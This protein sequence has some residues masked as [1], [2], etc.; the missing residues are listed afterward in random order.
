MKVFGGTGAEKGKMR[1]PHGQWLDARDPKKPVL[2]VCDRANARL[3]RFTLDGQVIDA[4]ESGKVVLFPAHAKTRG[5]VLLVPDLHARVSLFDKGNKV[6]CHLG[7]DGSQAD[8]DWR[9]KVLDGFKVRGQPK[10][11]VAGKF[12]HPHDACFDKDGNIFVVEWVATGRVTL[13]K[14]VG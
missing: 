6:I 3:Q 10:E 8:A 13:L 4:T 9:K 5:D 7:D 2:V 11:W 14:K 1:T 12:V